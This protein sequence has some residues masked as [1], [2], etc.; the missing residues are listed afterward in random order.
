MLLLLIDDFYWTFVDIGED[1]VNPLHVQHSEYDLLNACDFCLSVC[2]AVGVF[3]VFNGNESGR[4]EF[5]L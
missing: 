4:D 3:D 2:D 5:L 1:G